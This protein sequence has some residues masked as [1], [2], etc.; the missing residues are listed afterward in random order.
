MK[1]KKTV[2]K[3]FDYMQ[4]DD[5]AEYLSEMSLKGWHFKEWQ[6]GLVFEKGEP[7]E[8]EYAVEVFTEANENDTRPSP[9]T[10]E[11][12]EY[13]EAAGW[14]LIDGKQKFCI[15][16]KIQTDA[17]EILTPEERVINAFKASVSGTSTIMISLILF[18]V[19]AALQW[20]NFISFFNENIFSKNSL[21]SL[22][23][24]NLLFITYLSKFIKAF[25]KKHYFLKQIQYS[26]TLYMGRK[27]KLL[28]SGNTLMI[29][30]LIMILF[31]DFVAIGGT[32]SIIIASVILLSSF[33]L[34]HVIGKFRPDSD[35]NAIIQVFYGLLI[36]FFIVGFAGYQI[37]INEKVEPTIDDLPLLISDYKY[38]EAIIE[39]ISIYHQENI[40]GGYD[41]Y[42][43]WA[44]NDT[45]SYTVYRSEYTW[46]LDK[47]W[48]DEL[49]KKVN[50]N[51][52]YCSE[53]WEANIAFK[54]N[55]DEYL[56]RHDNSIL[57]FREYDDIDLTNEQIN[58]IRDKLNLR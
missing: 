4:C 45:V 47:I 56:V 58:I 16:K 38:N 55:A 48:E 37:I 8:I 54:N 46:I 51:I 11:F 28:I 39:D 30:L 29:F 10:K 40:F 53:N 12:A 7:Q 22:L 49:K 17:V 32:N 6:A 35:T 50:E 31:Y 25:F 18:G 2:L 21:F 15:F 20:I 26:N 3:T 44:T 9:K 24:W 1:N 13:C 23:V 52:T 42:F 5:F 33:I 41:T 19:N 27:N 43:I 36:A 14:Q 57:I 34:M